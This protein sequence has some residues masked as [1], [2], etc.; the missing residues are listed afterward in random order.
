MCVD[1]NVNPGVNLCSFLECKKVNMYKCVFVF[2]I[3]MYIRIFVSIHLC[4]YVHTAYIYTC[5]CI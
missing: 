3:R 4:I 2:L 5:I 1:V